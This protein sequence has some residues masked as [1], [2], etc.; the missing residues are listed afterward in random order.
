MFKERICYLSSFIHWYLD[1]YKSEAIATQRL[2]NVK[3]NNYSKTFDVEL[4]SFKLILQIQIIPSSFQLVF[5][6]I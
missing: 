2:K 6:C 1:K 3:F 5:F 4:N